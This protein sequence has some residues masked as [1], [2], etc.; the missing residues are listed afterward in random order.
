MKKHHRLWALLC[1]AAVGLSLLVG[2]P[3]AAENGT[4]P[5]NHELHAETVTVVDETTKLYTPIASNT[6]EDYNPFSRLWNG[7]PSVITAGNNIFVAWQ[8]GGEREPDP[9][10]LNYITVAASTDGG[11]TWKDPFMIIDPLEESRQA[12]V[13]M[14]YYNHAGQLY[15]LFSVEGLGIHALA[16]HNADG[17]L[18]GITYDEP[19]PV[20]VSNSSFT[21]PTLLSD[22]TILYSSGTTD[23][24]IFRSDDD[25]RSFEAIA[26][27]ES[28]TPAASRKFAESTLVE[29]KDGT[30]WQM[31]RLENSVNGG[32]E[33]SF[34]ADKGLNWTV[35]VGNLGSPLQSPGSRFNMQRLQ[36]GALL[37]VTNAEGMGSN[38][39]R[40]TAYLSEDDGDTWT[41]G[42]VL[43]ADIS[44]YPDFW[45]APDGTIY[46]V[47]DKDRYG[48]GGIRLCILTEEDAKAG[49]FVSEGAQQ[50][51][52]LTKT[53]YEYGVIKTVN[54][55][56]PRVAEYPV[57]TELETILADF[58]ATIS[59]T[60]DNGKTQTLT[61]RYRVS[62]FD[63][64]RAGTYR[65]YFIAD[66]PA[67]LKDSYSML[68]FEICLT[69]TGGCSGAIVWQGGAA[70]LAAV[71]LAAVLVFVS[72]LRRHSA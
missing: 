45:Q 44:S 55:A 23:A 17:P 61:G 68:E 5:V 19:F 42:L 6:E 57:G 51:I 27:I 46:I 10:K 16:I 49:A 24:R 9:N 33:Q 21:K 4:A 52:S 56:F 30:L 50:L 3:A 13:P 40:M 72:K 1:S 2:V 39:S 53:D 70:A 7:M 35:A 37:F 14:F 12:Q 62:N 54:G 43:D 11:I 66:L 71:V 36:S 31:R 26:T 58:P 65:A 60:D 47:F 15:L 67:K 59:V 69:E 32:I 18:T 48:E 63:A 28:N 64:Q 8:T 41:E 38:R 20:G 25:G 22:G 34:S 29:K